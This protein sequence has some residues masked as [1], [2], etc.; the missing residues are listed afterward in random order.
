MK[1]LKECDAPITFGVRARLGTIEKASQE[2]FV[3]LIAQ[4]IFDSN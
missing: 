4:E 2:D 1:E 3:P